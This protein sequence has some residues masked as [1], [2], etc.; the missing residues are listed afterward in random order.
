VA[1]QDRDGVAG[2]LTERTVHAV[3]EGADVGR[4]GVADFLTR[5]V[6][7]TGRREVAVARQEWQERASR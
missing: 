7:D 6:A 4:V 5:D 3:A 1:A 2:I